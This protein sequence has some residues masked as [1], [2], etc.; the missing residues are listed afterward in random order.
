M[1]PHKLT[2]HFALLC[3]VLFS[4]NTAGQKKPSGGRIAVVVDER[5]AALRASP[6]LNGRLVRRISR[7]RLVAIRSVKT[8]GPSSLLL[9]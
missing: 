3:L 4:T 5:L 9:R 8:T 2:L 6:E 1:N 7:G